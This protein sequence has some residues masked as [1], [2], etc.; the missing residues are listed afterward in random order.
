MVTAGFLASS[1]PLSDPLS[2]L[3]TSFGNWEPPGA[4]EMENT[5]ERRKV[6]KKAL[7]QENENN[8]TFP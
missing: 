1:P 6:L 3:F 4:K 8:E 5:A 7:Q 2:P